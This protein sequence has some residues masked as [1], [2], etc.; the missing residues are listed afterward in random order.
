M[1]R[2]VLL[3]QTHFVKAWPRYFSAYLDGTKPWS[4]RLD[5]RNYMDGDELVIQE[6]NSTEDCYTGRKASFRIVKVWDQ[7]PDFIPKGHVVL[8]LEPIVREAKG[9]VE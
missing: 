9:G 5:D 1:P 7:M 3:G 6:W 4:I 8:T 2:E